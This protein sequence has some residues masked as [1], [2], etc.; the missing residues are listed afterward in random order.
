MSNVSIRRA[1]VS[2]SRKEGLLPFVQ[3]LASKGVEILSTGGTAKVLREGGLAVKD[4]SEYTGSPEV[5]DGRVKTLHP[6]V[7]GGILAKRN[8]EH[9]KDLERLGGGAIDLVLVNFYPFEQVS[10]KPGATVDEV[11]ENIDIG[12]PSMVRSA[13]KNF[14]SVVVLVDPKDYD[15]VRAE[16][17]KEGGVSLPTRLRLAAKAFERTS[18][19]DGAIARYLSQVRAADGKLLK[20]EETFPGF[21]PLFFRKAQ[22]L[23]Y[24]ENPQQEAAFYRESD[25][26]LGGL[27]QHQGKELSFNN[28]IDLQ[29]AWALICDLPKPSCAIIKHTNPCGAARGKDAASAF[30]RARET[31][32]T[33]AF[34][35]IV[36]FNTT[37]TGEAA[38]ALSD[39]FLE[40]VVA[41]DFDP[42]ALEILSRKKNLRVVTLKDQDP[43]PGWDYKRVA[44]GL[45]VQTPDLFSHEEE[46]RVVTKR[47]PTKEEM[48]AMELAWRVCK[49]V[50]SNAIVFGDSDGTVGV[51][52]GQMSR[53]DSSKLARMKAYRDTKG[54]V[55][56][57]DA[58]FPFPDGVEEMAAAGIT[59]VIQ[60][61]GSIRDPEVI[62]AANRLGMAMVLTGTRHFRHG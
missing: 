51:G 35:G 20:G 9:L 53:V 8:P 6:R 23:R 1:L 11:V 39:L 15:A 21:L 49:H 13:A 61:G 25:R 47:K 24:G 36:A 62:E 28:L 5:M 41:P 38:T 4:V 33:S 52:A 27:V 60:P 56:A 3:F 34:G 45:L 55:A 29:G 59:A 50:K 2:V 26:F 44:G 32:P 22:D 16:I 30:K 40:I 7:H 19:Y 48:D 46:R 12:G 37:C 54:C 18:A 10:G 17:E 42:K 58:F 14:E 43:F 57:S 31:D